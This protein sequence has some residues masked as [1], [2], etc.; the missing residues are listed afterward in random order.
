MILLQRYSCCVFI[1]S[2]FMQTPLFAS[3]LTISDIQFE[4]NDVT[5]DQV[6]RQE[7]TIR[8]GDPLNEEAINT[9]RQSL[10]D[11][12][13]FKSVD[14]TTDD[15]GVVVFK[16]AEKHFILLIPRI[17]YD[18]DRD[19]IKPGIRLTINNLAG[20]NQRLKITY[21]QSDAEDA[22][23]G[24]QNEVGLEF[25]YPKI[26]GSAYNLSA[27]IKYLNSPL[28]YLQA[29]VP[30]SEYKKNDLGFSFIVSRWVYKTGPSSGWAS[31][32]G[33]RF[34]SHDYKYLSGVPGVFANDHAVSVLANISYTNIHDYLYSR[35]G[36]EF[37][38]SI[39]QGARW[40][41]SQYEFNRHQFYY[42]H[43]M[44]LG[45]IHHNLNVQ[46]RIGFSDGH[47]SNLAEDTYSINGYGDLRAY[48][49]EV[50]GDAFFL[51]NVEYL[52][53]I[54]GRNHIRSLIFV[55]V[56][57]TYLNNS[58]VT[59]SH[60]KWAAGLGIRWKLKSFVDLDLSM[61]YAHNMETD[62]NK[63]YFKTKGAF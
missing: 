59:F 9:S 4:G 34:D 61:E 25:D 29:G 48:V 56:G 43:Y 63:F 46:A 10:M 42:R 18:S 49:D 57:D 27:A 8:V 26:L 60:L 20:L 30:V 54:L 24:S 40:L 52:R 23:H 50:S 6:M 5:Q 51:L 7:L 12:G 1:L 44:H 53:P 55:D 36:K 19:K 28:Q 41:G 14:A 31:G 17:S 37:G 32:A 21:I 47:N 33:L 13:L 58:D 15:S 62:E 35:K 22:N 16:V 3:A 39:E 11:M 2:V 45:R 38:Y